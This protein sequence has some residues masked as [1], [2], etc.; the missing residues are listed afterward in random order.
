MALAASTAVLH[1]LATLWGRPVAATPALMFAL[2]MAALL[3]T[4][5]WSTLPLAFQPAGARQVGTYFGVAHAHEML[6][7]GVVLG[8]LAGVYQHGARLFGRT[9]DPHLGQLHFALTLVGA[10]ATFLPMHLLGLAGMPRR[11]HTYPAAMGWGGLNL[12]A[13]LGTVVLV[14]A[15]VVFAVALLRAKRVDADAARPGGEVALPGTPGPALAA[16]GLALLATGTLLGWLVGTV[17]AGLLAVGGW[18]MA[19][20]WRG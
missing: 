2:G 20:D 8:L 14:G 4:G 17:G 10:F 6:F 5:A 13:T 16:S 7:G 9:L 18:R 15:G 11:I 12:L 1:W 3:M 19:R